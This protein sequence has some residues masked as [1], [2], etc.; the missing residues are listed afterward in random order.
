MSKKKNDKPSYIRYLVLF[1]AIF[2]LGA[3]AA[4]GYFYALS[5]SWLWELPSFEE[6]ENPKSYL[7]T[8]IITSDNQLLGKYFRENRTMVRYENLPPHLVQALI[9]TEDERYYDH[10]GIDIRGTIRAVAYL[11]GKG[12][13]STITQQLAKLLFHETFGSVLAKK[14]WSG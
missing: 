8:E 3:L 10:S 4:T 6:L 13:A 5:Q 9:A 11:G 14:P 1:W 7:A 12:G 2:S